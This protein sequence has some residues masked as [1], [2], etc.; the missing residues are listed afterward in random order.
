MR[1]LLLSVQAG[2]NPY[3]MTQEF[4]QRIGHFAD[5]ATVDCK[6][7]QDFHSRLKKE[8]ASGAV[9]TVMTD[10][11]GKLCTSEEFASEIGKARDGGRRT[12]IFAIG[13]PDGWKPDDLK[14]GDLTLSMGRL[15]LPHQLARLILAEQI[16]RAFTILAGHPYHNGH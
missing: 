13:P 10:S 7:I 8:A 16:Y 5:V 3:D 14:V 11:R 6:S 12:L 15:T 2:R 1:V 9:W 4:L